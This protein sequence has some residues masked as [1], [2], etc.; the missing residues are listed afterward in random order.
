MIYF[1][2]PIYNEVP[3]LELLAVNLKKIL[4]KEEKFYVF[5]DDGS[6]DNSVQLI[7]QLFEGEDYKCL[8]DGSNHGPGYAFNTGFEWILNQS[9]NKEDIVVTLEADNT[10]DLS[11]L[12]KML[13]I[14]R[15]DFD[16]VLASIYAQG[17]GFEQTS[18]I[19]KVLSF[20][21]NMFFRSFFDVKI[22]TLS[23]FYRVYKV[24]L[25]RKIQANYSQIIAE[26]GFISMLEMLLKAI[27]LKAKMLEVPMVLHSSKRKGKS[28][29]KLMKTV[30][31][32]LR[33]FADS[34]KILQRKTAI[35]ATPAL[36]EVA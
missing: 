36:N 34:K 15:L 11:I 21:A 17:G 5:S 27:N 23:S 3:N 2:I 22:L 29:M 24:E 19:R 35:K 1:L 9:K 16:L 4:P 28:K 20:L 8:G 32:Y 7:K 18:F 30:M 6:S 10:S 12:P 25:L 14:A 26:S 13:G 31:S 33:F